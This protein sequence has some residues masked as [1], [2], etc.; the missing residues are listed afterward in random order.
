MT[1]DEDGFAEEMAAQKTRSKQAEAARRC[2]VCVC[3]C[4]FGVGG[5]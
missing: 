2:S 4:V 3:V 5:G 1:V